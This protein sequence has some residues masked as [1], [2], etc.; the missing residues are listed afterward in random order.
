MDVTTELAILICADGRSVQLGAQAW[1]GELSAPHRY[2]RRGIVEW[3]FAW[4]HPR[5]GA[6]H[7]S[8]RLGHAA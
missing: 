2:E 6:R 5:L 7:D 8:S 4:F 3:F 1:V